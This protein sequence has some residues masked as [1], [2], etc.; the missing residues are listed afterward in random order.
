MDSFML[1]LKSSLNYVFN[2][3][4]TIA[5]IDSKLCR[6]SYYLLLYSH[7]YCPIY[8]VQYFL[9]YS[10]SEMFSDLAIL[11]HQCIL[12]FKCLQTDPVQFVFP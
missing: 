6:K 12:L 4:W 8:K 2:L 10:I 1:K 7:I 11:V 5:S 9:F 3:D